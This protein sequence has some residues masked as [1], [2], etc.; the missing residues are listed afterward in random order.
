MVNGVVADS[1]RANGG[2]VE[3]DAILHAQH[4]GGRKWAKTLVSHYILPIGLR[5]KDRTGMIGQP[6]E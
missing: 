6:I 3:A 1:A 4:L 2:V 5:L